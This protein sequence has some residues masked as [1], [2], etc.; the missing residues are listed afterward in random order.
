[1]KALEVYEGSDGEVTKRYYA[2][3]QRAGAIGLVA[4]NLFRAQKCSARAKKYR[5]GVRGVGSF[6]GMAYE[7]KQWS[8]ANLAAVLL[9]HGESLGIAWGWKRDEAA[10]YGPDWVLYIDLPQGQVSFHSPAR[11]E[12]PDYSGDWDR[13]KASADRILAFCD[14]VFHA[15]DPRQQALAIS[16]ADDPGS[17]PRLQP[18][19]SFSPGTESQ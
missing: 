12:G 2:E 18:D 6:R 1:M 5:G 17:L 7:R 19:R 14:A 16:S 3:L 4:M 13:L 10:Q 11:G 8:M 15:P 9:K